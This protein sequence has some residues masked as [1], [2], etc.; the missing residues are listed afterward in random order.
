MPV[1]RYL[2]SYLQSPTTTAFRDS[3]SGESLQKN[4]RQTTGYARVFLERTKAP[5]EGPSRSRVAQ[6]TSPAVGS[7]VALRHHPHQQTTNST[8]P[9]A[10][11]FLSRYIC[12][13]D[14]QTGASLARI[15]SYFT[16]DDSWP[17]IGGSSQVIPSLPA[18][19]ILACQSIGKQGVAGWAR[20]N[21]RILSSPNRVK[22]NGV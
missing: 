22:K 10:V 21:L 6:R 3:I 13:R 17:F 1:L 19:T 4:C 12:S 7:L 9:P 16:V 11:P 20:P 5:R 15:A 8:L 2:L 18:A 14:R